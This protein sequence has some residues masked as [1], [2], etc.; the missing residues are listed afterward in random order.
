MSEAL[1]RMRPAEIEHQKA[2]NRLLQLGA[3]MASRGSK[4]SKTPGSTEHSP[5][6]LSLNRLAVEEDIMMCNS[7]EYLLSRNEAMSIPS[8]LIAAPVL[9][10][11]PSVV[12]SIKR[13][14]EVLTMPSL[15]KYST[16]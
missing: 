9:V 5:V 3:I 8:Y 7:V 1:K 14:L 16:S 12:N 10:P 6:L 11:E 13:Y 2:I 15:G 4:V